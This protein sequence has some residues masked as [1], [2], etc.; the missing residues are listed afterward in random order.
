M[1]ESQRF[2]QIEE[3]CCSI[4]SVGMW[5]DLPDFLFLSI[6]DAMDLNDEV[7]VISLYKN[8]GRNYIEI[9]LH[10]PVLIF[11]VESLQSNLMVEY[12]RTLYEKKQ[13][14]DATLLLDVESCLFI[15]YEDDGGA[16]PELFHKIYNELKEIVSS[17]RKYIHD[18]QSIFDNLNKIITFAEK[19]KHEYFLY[20]K[21][22]WLSLYFHELSQ[23]VADKTKLSLYR[24]DLSYIFPNVKL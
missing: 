6:A 13:G 17:A 7:F 16:K 11:V 24:D 10:S 18:E 8:I 19:N 3:K 12:I 14:V 2:Q 15:N 4:M 9:L 22:Y 21:A 5:Y 20:I 1:N 23:Y